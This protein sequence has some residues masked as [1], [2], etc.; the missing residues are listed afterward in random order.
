MNYY[1]LQTAV[2][3][4]KQVNKNLSDMGKELEVIGQ[5]TSVGDLP[6]KLAHAEEAK[7]EVEG[8]LLQRVG[9]LN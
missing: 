7:V 2:K 1:S 9:H 5:F 4:C 8:Q 6:E 3:S